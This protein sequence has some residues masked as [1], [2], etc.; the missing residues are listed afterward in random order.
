MKIKSRIWRSHQL[1]LQLAEQIATQNNI[2]VAPSNPVGARRRLL[3][4]VVGDGSDGVVPKAEPQFS[5]PEP[6]GLAKVVKILLGA[7]AIPEYLIDSLV[8][9]PDALLVLILRECKTNLPVDPFPRSGLI[10][11]SNPIFFFPEFGRMREPFPVHFPRSNPGVKKLMRDY[12]PENVVRR[13]RVVKCV[14][15]P[16]GGPIH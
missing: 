12:E 5:P 15:Y 11:F 1:D 2:A 16:D 7:R 10:F 3:F 9:Y 8:I 14:V 13:T 6:E 4:F